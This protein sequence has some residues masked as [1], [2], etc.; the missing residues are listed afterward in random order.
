MRRVLKTLE[1]YF[2]LIW[3]EVKGLKTAKAI[4]K[5]DKGKGLRSTNPFSH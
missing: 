2:W 1:N 3:L 5:I 4:T